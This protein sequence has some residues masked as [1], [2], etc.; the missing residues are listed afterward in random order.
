MMVEIY[1]IR[2]KKYVETKAK[3]KKLKNKRFA[4]EGICPSCKSKIFKIVK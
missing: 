1:C 3:R 2:C 4:L